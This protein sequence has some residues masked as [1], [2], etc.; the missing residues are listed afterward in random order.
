MKRFVSTTAINASLF[1]KDQTNQVLHSLDKN[2]CTPR[3]TVEDATNHTVKKKPAQAR[4]EFAKIKG[5][6]I[7]LK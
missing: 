2:G 4:A 1:K 5:P 7:N 3:L 6:N